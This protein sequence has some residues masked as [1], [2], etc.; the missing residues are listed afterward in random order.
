ML[1]SEQD[2]VTHV[3][4]VFLLGFCCQFGDGLETSGRRALTD[5][6]QKLGPD[7]CRMSVGCLSD[8]GAISV[9]FWSNV[10]SISAPLNGRCVQTGRLFGVTFGSIQ[11]FVNFLAQMWTHVNTIWHFLHIHVRNDP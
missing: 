3:R 4:D 5:V 6:R 1:L 9:P 8:L 7:V 2:Y 10:G 11:F